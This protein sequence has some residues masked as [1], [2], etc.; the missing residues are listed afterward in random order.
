M[1]LSIAG[2]SCAQ[3]LVF[4]S[5]SVGLGH[6][7]E[8]AFGAASDALAGIAVLLVAMAAAFACLAFFP[9]MRRRA[10]APA[11]AAALSVLPALLF[12]ACAAFGLA[13]PAVYAAY[14]LLGIAGSVLL[15]GWG[16]LLG[17]A[18]IE[19]SV[20]QVF[21]A[22]AIGAGLCILAY[23]LPVPAH[24]AVAAMP[25]VSAALFAE[26]AR[27]YAHAEGADAGAPVVGGLV[28]RIPADAGDL[29]DAAR[30]PRDT[31]GEA[32]SREKDHTSRDAHE[33][34]SAREEGAQALTARIL[35]GT[36]MFGLAA[37]LAEA[38][39]ASAP[40]AFA[41]SIP[42]VLVLFVVFCIAALQLFGG[43]TPARGAALIEA[44]DAP[45]SAGAGPLDGSYRLALLLMLA[46][47][48]LAPLL[49][50]LGIAEA[51]VALAGYLGL[52]T[53]LMALFLVM[54]HVGGHDATASFARG[55]AS[56]F[57]GQIVGVAAGVAVSAFVPSLS[58]A[59]LC[60]AAGVA[61]LYGF[62]YLFTERDMHALSVVVEDVDRFDEACARIAHDG[63]LSKR[64]SEVLPLVLRGRTSERIAAELC[65]S[66]NTVD[67]HIRRIYAKC[68][69]HSRQELIDLG[70]RTEAELSGARAASG[71][72]LKGHACRK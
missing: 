9:G 43:K 14:A 54:A 5:L 48:L 24:A 16:W 31:T 25:I 18:P 4:A 51:V 60:P 56:L 30:S 6:L 11:V 52:S 2:L 39:D 27:R 23:A 41:G 32:P 38:A 26:C 44:S 50:L 15:N 28:L 22:S 29:Q 67:T 36:A 55:F 53:V 69:V 40:L 71:A 19:R 35:V 17:T 21:L 3:C 63:A 64:E 46:G 12:A 58:S 20:P 62:L 61:V 1:W 72:S 10:L 65:I 47:L 37:G 8:A 33:R 34:G 42:L 59:V 68:G 49:G 7:S 45:G 13:E 57:G 66:R 70:E